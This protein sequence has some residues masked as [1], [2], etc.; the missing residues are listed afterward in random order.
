MTCPV[1]IA[2]T[3]AQVHAEFLACL[4]LSQLVRPGTP[5]MYCCFARG[6][7]MK[8]VNVSMSSP[9]FAILRGAAAQMAHYIGLPARTAGLLRDAKVL[10]AQS[11][12]E[13]GSVGVAAVLAADVID[14]LQYDMD[15]LV[16]FADLVF[17][18]EAIGALK[19]IARG[20][21]ID[22]NTLALNVIGEVGHGGSFLNHKHTRQNFRKELWMPSLMERRS[23]AQWQKDGAKDAEQRSREKAREIL[24]T[25]QPT[26][27]A[28]EAEEEID[29][30]VA[31]ATIDYAKSI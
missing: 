13:S 14:G 24:A 11:G 2:G 21:L 23:W 17:N 7:D 3:L 9:E 15:T 25:H 4:V 18:N 16:D 1:T 19:R 29:R 27:L 5:V 12:F 31:Q 20:F 8:T 10:D 22:D 30:I 28:P 26:R 6:F